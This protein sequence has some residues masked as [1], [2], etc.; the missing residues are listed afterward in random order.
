MF[1]HLFQFFESKS[2]KFLKSGIVK[3]NF[4]IYIKQKNNNEI[5]SFKFYQREK[6]KHIYALSDKGDFYF[7]KIGE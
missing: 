7:L 6:R 5:E 3:T 1:Y 4:S 2:G